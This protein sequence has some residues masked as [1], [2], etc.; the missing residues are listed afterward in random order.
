V[1]SQYIPLLNEPEVSLLISQ[2]RQWVLAFSDYECS[3]LSYCRPASSKW[4]R[5]GFHSETTCAVR[6]S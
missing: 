2:H 6:I 4:F 1:T 5:S 3:L